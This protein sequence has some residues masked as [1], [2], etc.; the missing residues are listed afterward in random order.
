MGVN[1]A[2]TRS[3]QFP[4]RCMSRCAITG[5][6]SNYKWLWSEKNYSSSPNKLLYK[7]L[8]P[9][10]PIIQINKCFYSICK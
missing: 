6:N 2:I 8:W 4:T 3:N 1:S 9:L 7:H 5:G 10:T